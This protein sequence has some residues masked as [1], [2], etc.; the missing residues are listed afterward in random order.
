VAR[1]VGLIRSEVFRRLN[2]EPPDQWNVTVS[3]TVSRDLV[4][5]NTSCATLLSLDARNETPFAI[6]SVHATRRIF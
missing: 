2:H 5:S 6:S 1:T 3:M 4:G